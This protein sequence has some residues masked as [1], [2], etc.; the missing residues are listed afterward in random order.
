MNHEIYYQISLDLSFPHTLSI[1]SAGFLV[2]I[3]GKNG[4]GER[5]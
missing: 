2:S 3:N 1:L 5:I 4:R